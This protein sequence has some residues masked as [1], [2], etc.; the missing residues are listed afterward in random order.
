MKQFMVCVDASVFERFLQKG[1][2]GVEVL[3]GIPE[4]SILV[5]VYYHLRRVHLYF[6]SEVGGWNV[7]DGTEVPEMRVIV[8]HKKCDLLQELERLN[9]DVYNTK[10]YVWSCVGCNETEPT[11]KEDTFSYRGKEDV[12]RSRK[13]E[14]G[15]EMKLIVNV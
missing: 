2:I 15:S 7:V 9:D 5:N 8:T 11:S 3:E 6:M 4:D 12:F 1:D 10:K 14:C 13:C